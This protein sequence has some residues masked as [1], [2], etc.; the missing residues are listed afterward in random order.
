MSGVTNQPVQ[1]THSN[2]V[3][4]YRSGSRPLPVP[5]SSSKFLPSLPSAAPIP[6]RIPNPVRLSNPSPTVSTVARQTLSVPA[7]FNSGRPLPIPPSKPKIVTTPPISSPVSGPVISSNPSNNHSILQS[8][9]QPVPALTVTKS[10]SNTRSILNRSTDSQQFLE[11]VPNYT[12]ETQTLHYMGEFYTFLSRNSINISLNKWFLAG[13]CNEQELILLNPDNCLRLNQEFEKILRKLEVL[14]ITHE[15]Q[16]IKLVMEHVND[17][18]SYQ[19]NIEKRIIENESISLSPSQEVKIVNIEEFIKLKEGVCRHYSIITAYFLDRLTHTPEGNPYLDGIVQHIRDYIP[20]GAHAWNTFV[21]STGNQWHIDPTWRQ[22]VNL[23]G[24]PNLEFLIK[25]YGI[26]AFTNEVQCLKETAQLA[27]ANKKTTENIE[28][29]QKNAFT[30]EEA[31]MFGNEDA[32]KGNSHQRFIVI[33]PSSSDT[34]FNVISFKKQENYKFLNLWVNTKKNKIHLIKNERIIK[35][36]DSL[37]E[38]GLG[39]Q[40]TREEYNRSL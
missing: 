21:S 26:S 3:L 35:T 15:S 11:D 32:K 30:E 38:L 14:K 40:I 22:A 6:A 4:A 29:L 34:Y 13:S 23:K 33:Q 31:T 25:N 24:V 28:V 16:V 10:N 1:S 8:Q 27:K 17:L 2:T 37:H 36:Y 7:S 5:K 18:I 19:G 39:K 12:Q 20:E 9:S